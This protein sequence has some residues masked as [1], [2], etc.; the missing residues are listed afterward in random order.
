[1]LRWG[2]R[3]KK[4]G[5]N[6]LAELEPLPHD[7]PKE[8]R[9]LTN[10]KVKRLLER[11]PQPWRDIWYAYL[12]ADMRKMELANLTFPDIDWQNRELIVRGSKSKNKKER[13]IP[14][15]SGLEE[16]IAKQ[17]AGRE[18]SKPGKG[19]TAKLTAKTQVRFSKDHVFVSTQNTPLTHSSGLYAA[20]M[21]CCKL[22]GIQTQTC[23]ANGRL[24]E[25]MD[26]HSLRRTFRHQLDRGRGRPEERDGSARPQHAGH[27]H[28]DL[29]QG[30]G[31]HQTAGPGQPQLRSGHA[32][33]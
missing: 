3:Q 22:A 2:V 20:F 16:I 13:R 24:V 9:P 25:H 11:S 31:R 15:D 5:S 32:C 7:N 33:P 23:D 4:I 30:Q 18:A 19:K 14:M 10:D 8:G 26:V 12:V 17:E 29:R 27:H 21:R 6:P 1:M 28:A